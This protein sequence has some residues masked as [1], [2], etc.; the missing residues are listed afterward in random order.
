MKVS[1][2]RHFRNKL[3]AKQTVY[4]LWVTLE[5]A[6]IT[7][8]A[9]ALGFDW[10]LIDL[11][12]GHLDWHN[13]LEHIRATVRSNTV[14]LVRIPELQ[15]GLI[16]RALDIG[17]D[18]IIIP[19][20][21]TAEELKLAISFSK[22]PPTGIRGVG[23]ERATAWGQCIEENVSEANEH[24]MVIPMIESVKGGENIDSML[25]TPGSEIFFFGPV[26]YCASA[27]FAGKMSIPFVN[28]KITLAKNKILAA[29]QYCG[30]FTGNPQD[31]MA[32]KEQGFQMIPYGVDAGIFI[33]AM[34][35]LADTTGEGSRINSAFST[36]QTA[37]QPV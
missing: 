29:K 3:N 6:T 10:V 20:I 32:K 31:I 8:M 18:G 22:Y 9:V 4:G 30:I 13:V 5:S 33:K 1:A 19:R 21:E 12:H 17:A 28:E 36:E 25:Q 2:L 34:R 27:G 26:D 23:V 14:A 35:Q 16:K 15:E 7:E 24:V 11:E 37:N